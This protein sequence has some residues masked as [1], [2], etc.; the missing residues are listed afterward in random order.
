MKD[1]PREQA[2]MLIETAAQELLG[3]VS[4]GVNLQVLLSTSR[5]FW[6]YLE[7]KGT[8]RLERYLEVALVQQK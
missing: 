7:V 1:R 5:S 6:G 2:S 3:W 4:L 8:W